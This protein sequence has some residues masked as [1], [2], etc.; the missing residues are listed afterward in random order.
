[1]VQHTWRDRGW[2]SPEKS[3]LTQ[4]NNITK[5]G[6]ALKLCLYCQMAHKWYDDC[7]ESKN[8]ASQTDDIEGKLLQEQHA[9]EKRKK[10]KDLTLSWKS[11]AN[12]NISD[13]VMEENNRKWHSPHSNSLICLGCLKCKYLV[14]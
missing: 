10:K 14:K 2:K 4:G 7:S 13:A 5:F 12:K 6:I 9:E 1:M 3:Q 11:T 8:K